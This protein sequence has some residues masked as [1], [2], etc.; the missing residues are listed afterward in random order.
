MTTNYEFTTEFLTVYIENQ[1]SH[2]PEYSET[3]SSLTVSAPLCMCNSQFST[4]MPLGM[5]ASIFGAC[6]LPGQSGRVVAGRASGI[7]EGGMMEVGR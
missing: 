3:F 6:P 4:D 5:Q 2:R 1:S 7:K